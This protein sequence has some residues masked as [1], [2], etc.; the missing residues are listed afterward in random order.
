MLGKTRDEVAFTIHVGENAG[1][2]GKIWYYC[3]IHMHRARFQSNVKRSAWL[4]KKAWSYL[5]HMAWV[6]R[7]KQISFRNHSF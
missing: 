1:H 4:K 2:L 7:K 3:F 5:N 6:L